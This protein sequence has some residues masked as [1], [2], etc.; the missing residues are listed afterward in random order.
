MMVDDGRA[1]H[2]KL[3][4]TNFFLLLQLLMLIPATAL[5]F[6][7]PKPQ[8]PEFTERGQLKIT[9]LI[10]TFDFIVWKYW[11]SMEIENYLRPL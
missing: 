8:K 9:P 4:Q 6:P 10:I 7:P 5:Q 11:I 2:D 1:A 3:T